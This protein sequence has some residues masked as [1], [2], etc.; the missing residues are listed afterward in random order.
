MSTRILLV[1]DNEVHCL[2]TEDFLVHQGY[3]VLSLRDGAGFL[4]AIADFKPDIVLLDLKLPKIDGFSLLEK[5]RCSE[6]RSL[7]VIVLS[8]YAFEREKQKALAL[9]VQCYLTKPVNLKSLAQVVERE[10]CKTQSATDFQFPAH[11]P[12]G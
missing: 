1:E 5:L 2:L 12:V 9:G 11:F 6:W 3:D 8:A 7:P 4:T 10:I